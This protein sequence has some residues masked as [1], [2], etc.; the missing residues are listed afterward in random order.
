MN[1]D[2]DSKLLLLLEDEARQ[3]CEDHLYPFVRHAWDVL[4]PQTEFKNNWHIGLTCEHLEAVQLR[5]IQHLI[6][7]IPPRYLK[8]MMCTI[9]FPAWVWVKD[10]AHR[11]ITS[12]YG[13]TLSSDL[14]YKRRLLIESQ[15]YRNNWGH[16]V[17]LLP[18]YNQKT[19]YKNTKM[20]FMF[21]TST[22]GAVTGE[23]C[24]TMVIDDPI[25]PK[26]AESDGAREKAINHWKQTLSTR[27]NDPKNYGLVLVMQRLHENDLTGHLLNELDNVTHLVIPNECEERTVYS[28]PITSGKKIYEEGEILHPER[29]G[30]QELDN[31]KSNLGS[32]GYAAQKQQSPVPRKGGIINGDWFKR[33]L[34]PPDVY[35]L[36][37]ISV[38]CSFKNLQTSDYVAIGTWLES[39][40]NYY[41]T[42]V[43]R[44]KLSFTETVKVLR[45]IL[46]VNPD[47]NAILIE[48]KANGTAVINTLEDEFTGIV[49][50][51]PKDSKVSRLYAVSPMFEA[52]NVWIPD[53]SV[54]NW[55]ADYLKEMIK[56]PKATNDDQVDMTTQFLNW[57]KQKSSGTLTDDDENY[58]GTIVGS[59]NSRSY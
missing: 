57:I 5:Q 9:C 41:L 17:Q 51:N 29:E 43:L 6:I 16:Q 3:D 2:D 21:A 55:V 38:D 14:S 20:G 46:E 13:D 49:P 36:K 4:E 28:F 10:P 12:S 50:I 25:K 30:K 32:F 31:A 19:M 39:R 58:N 26:D 23:G 52:G 24:G 56:F 15:W 37:V 47:Y 42:H 53:D 18:D 59:I 54:S 27:F 8:S 34:F 35:D 45:N 48:D 22:G 40:A 11:F 33:F 1:D 44:Q 7:N